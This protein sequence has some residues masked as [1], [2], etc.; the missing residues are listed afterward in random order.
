MMVTNKLKL[1]ENSYYINLAQFLFRTMM[2]TLIEIKIIKY[3][4][5]IQ[6]GLINL[7]T[8]VF[9]AFISS[10]KPFLTTSTSIYHFYQN[11]LF[12][13]FFIIDIIELISR[14]F[15][16]SPFNLQ[17]FHAIDLVY[18]KNDFPIYF[19]FL[20]ITIL[21]IIA[22][23]FFPF[24][25]YNV[26]IKSVILVIYMS[27]TFI[28]LFFLS[29]IHDLVNVH[30]VSLKKDLNEYDLYLQNLLLKKIN[31][32]PKVVNISENNIKNL[33][34]LQLESFP[35]EFI[36]QRITPNLYN[37][38]QKYE[39]IES[40]KSEPY[41]TWSTSSIVVTQCGIPQILPD[42]D[43]SNRLKVH[44]YYM[45]YISCIS[46][47]LNT[48][49]YKRVYSIKGSEKV[50]GYNLW[51]KYKKY[52]NILQAKG[53]LEI[54][55]FF[56]EN[57]LPK[58]DKDVRENG[59]YA[60]CHN[61]SNFKNHSIDY[62]SEFHLESD[63]KTSTFPSRYLIYILFED[64][65]I[66]Y[67]KQSWCKLNSKGL[68]KNEQCFNCDDIAVNIFVNKYLELKMYEHTVL[69]IYPDHIPYGHGLEKNNDHLF[70]LFPGI[71]KNNSI[72]KDK[73]SFSY[74]D[75]APTILDMIGINNYLP[76]FPF[77]KSIYSNK[78]SN[79]L[80]HRKPDS[81]D[82]ELIY[83]YL[84][85]DKHMKN[86]GVKTKKKFKCYLDYKKDKSFDS[87]TPCNFTIQ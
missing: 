81:H 61:K 45:N 52:Q 84:N 2:F 33:I 66:P 12:S 41:T 37:L 68:A 67:K 34:L 14:Y 32:H 31:M 36:N 4:E 39:F 55:N 19:L 74:Y 49:G 85:N 72:F 56:A 20:F 44:M 47:I 11:I 6:R 63:K 16:R 30:K 62:M 9:V 13:F 22:L 82:L 54:A 58:M 46:D 25:K 75:F 83:A 27:N 21:S 29:I 17:A 1:L 26:K 79:Y 51:R 10:V 18:I 71:K 48:V 69:A 59:D 3:R 60:I 8:Y 50:M 64:T 80:K 77:G 23:N 15:T 5:N 53:D 65:H 73:D 7:V 28:F 87:D 40:I 57:F 35:Y 38:S 78:S 43:D 42:I 86:F 70:V 76:E 24:I